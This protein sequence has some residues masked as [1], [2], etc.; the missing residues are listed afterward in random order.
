MCSRYSYLSFTVF[1]FYL[2]S[3]ILLQL[4]KESRR[5]NAEPQKGTIIDCPFLIHT[6]EVTSCGKGCVP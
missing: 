5:L 2:H 3:L 6:N 4:N 1:G